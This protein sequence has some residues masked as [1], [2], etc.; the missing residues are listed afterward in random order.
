[1]ELF[2]ELSMGL[3]MELSIRRSIELL[4]GQVQDRYAFVSP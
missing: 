3:F 4:T 2:I 1:M